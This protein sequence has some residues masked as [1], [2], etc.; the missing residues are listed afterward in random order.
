MGNRKIIKNSDEY[1]Y[2]KVE[3]VDNG[4]VKSQIQRRYRR[5]KDN[6][7]RIK[8]QKI[9]DKVWE[10]IHPYYSKSGTEYRVYIVEDPLEYRIKNV[11]R[12][13]YITGGEGVKNFRGIKRA[14]KTRLFELGVDFN[15]ELRRDRATKE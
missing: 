15:Y 7:H 3:V 12:G 5:R 11:K 10:S 14:V 9:S 2:K 13:T 4:V 6:K 8:Y 1:I